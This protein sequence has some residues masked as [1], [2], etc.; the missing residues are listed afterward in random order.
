MPSLIGQSVGG[1]AGTVGQNFEK[2]DT[3]TFMGTRAL[4][5]YK[6]H[7]LWTIYCYAQP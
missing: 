1:G 7:G 5:F 4:S 2:A 3:T 6:V